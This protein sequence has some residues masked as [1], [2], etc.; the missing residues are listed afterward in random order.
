MGWA[1]KST[2]YV[3]LPLQCIFMTAAS[4]KPSMTN[5]DGY[6]TSGQWDLI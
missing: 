2:S 4:L 3:K 5:R 1:T 6:A